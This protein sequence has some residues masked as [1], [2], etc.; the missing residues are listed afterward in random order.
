MYCYNWQIKNVE[1]EFL[2]VKRTLHHGKNY[3]AA[4]QEKVKGSPIEALGVYGNQVDDTLNY[5]VCRYGNNRYTKEAIE[6]NAA[7]KKE[8]AALNKNGHFNYPLID[9]TDNVK[10]QA[11][12]KQFLPVMINGFGANKLKL[13]EY[14]EKSV[15][16]K[17]VSFE[18]YFIWSFHSYYTA[19]TNELIKRKLIILP[20]GGIAFFAAI[21]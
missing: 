15:Y 8:L 21:K 16:A 2:H 20:P 11:M 6:K 9:S 17:E 18:E 5:I 7:V 10:L 19:V 1:A 13:V 14:Y 12:A 4:Y 3:Y